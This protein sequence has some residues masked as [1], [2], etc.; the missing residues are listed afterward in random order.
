MLDFDVGKAI[1]LTFSGVAAAFIAIALL[2]TLTLL[3]RLTGRIS[4]RSVGSGVQ[5]PP[6]TPSEITEGISVQGSPD[7]DADVVAAIATAVS[8]AVEEEETASMEASGSAAISGWRSYGRWQ[9]AES[10]RLW[11]RHG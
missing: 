8:M 9:A 3:T 2:I 7:P 11:K 10:R 5:G 4:N 6:E 1:E